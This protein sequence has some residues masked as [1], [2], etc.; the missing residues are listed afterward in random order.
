MAR[1][2][3]II[4]HCGNLYDENAFTGSSSALE[5]NNFYR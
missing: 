1:V 4:M 5:A 3:G 2:L